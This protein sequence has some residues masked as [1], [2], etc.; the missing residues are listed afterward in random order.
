MLERYEQLLGGQNGYSGLK[1][2][3]VWFTKFYE[4][5]ILPI[6]MFKSNDWVTAVSPSPT[7]LNI[8]GRFLL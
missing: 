5:G 4:K 1:S 6:T 8:V 2:H 7:W 3:F